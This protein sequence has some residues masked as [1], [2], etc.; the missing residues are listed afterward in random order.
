MAG[1][2]LPPGVIIRG[3]DITPLLRGEPVEWDDDLYL[4]YSMHH[5]ATT[6]MRGYRT[7][8]WKLIR[9]FAHPGRS[10]LYD[11]QNDPNELT[12]L[13]ESDEPLHTQIREKLSRKILERMRSLND[14]ALHESP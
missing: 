9:D 4:E 2:D 6:H 11:L 5:G 3:R 12:N 7:S 13:V 14:A 1:V 8:R 10:E